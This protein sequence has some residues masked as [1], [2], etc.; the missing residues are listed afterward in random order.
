MRSV[1][2]GWWSWLVATWASA[3]FAIS[4]I[5]LFGD[6]GDEGIAH[7]VA[8]ALIFLGFAAATAA[9]LVVRRRAPRLAAWLLI[10]GV[11]LP[12][13]PGFS[14]WMFVP[15]AIALVIIVGGV[16]TGEIRFRR[17]EPA[18]AG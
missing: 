14:V 10:V 4:V 13:L 17:P 2:T 7:R 1:I 3:S 11:G 5:A 16:T 9:A 15:T 6:D 12:G 18:G 8:F